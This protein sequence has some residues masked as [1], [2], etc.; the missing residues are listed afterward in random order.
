M[1]HRDILGIDSQLREWNSRGSRGGLELFQI[2]LPNGQTI[3][4]DVAATPRERATG[5]SNIPFLP[6]G[7]GMLLAFPDVGTHLITTKR[8]R[9]PLDILWLG[10]TKQITWWV[11]ECGGVYPWKVGDGGTY[12]PKGVSQ[13]VL[14]IGALEIRR[15]GLK[16]G[17]TL[18]WAV[19]RTWPF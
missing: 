17:D 6:Q 2:F 7:R 11:S 3:L 16:L 15:Q 14:E 5:L 4:A 9:F 1:T 13:W 12:T 18:R 19:V 10:P 8:M